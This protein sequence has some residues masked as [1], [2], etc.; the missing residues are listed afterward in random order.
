MHA[1]PAMVAVA[2]TDCTFRFGFPD[3]QTADAE[4]K[5]SEAMYLDPVEHTTEIRG[6]G[7]AHL[8]L[9]ELK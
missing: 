3:G 1:H 9:I 2:I 7:E 5:P 8:L 4:L 6:T